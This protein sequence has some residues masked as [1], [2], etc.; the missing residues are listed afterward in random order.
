MLN[1]ELLEKGIHANIIRLFGR[2]QFKVKENWS[3][4]YNAIVDTGA[5]FSLLPLEIWQ[6]AEIEILTD[7]VVRGLIPKKQCILPVK[8]GK[9][10]VRLID[11]EDLLHEVHFN[12][13]ID[14]T[15]QYIHLDR[16]IA[17]K[18]FS[19]AKNKGIS[20]DVLVNTWLKEKLADYYK[21]F[22]F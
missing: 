14:K 18:V 4:S 11:E 1:L 12:V 13:Q 22:E 3:E 21:L 10:T 20:A 5:P 17:E 19:L 9:T 15:S 6:E 2:V 8:V 7:T 16:E